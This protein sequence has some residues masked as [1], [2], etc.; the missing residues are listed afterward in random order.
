MIDAAEQHARSFP[1]GSK[2]LACGRRPWG[3]VLV[4]IEIAEARKQPAY[5]M[6]DA[7]AVAA[8]TVE[9]NGRTYLRASCTY[10]CK[11]CFPAL[12]RAAAKGGPS[13]AIVEIDAPGR[14]PSE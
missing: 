11:E 4:F 13:H 7:G 9:R 10:A 1:K 12:E 2:C 14:K 5:Y 6:L 3:R 8:A